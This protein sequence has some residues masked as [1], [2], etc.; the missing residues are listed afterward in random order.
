[1][2]ILVAESSF[3]GSI[4]DTNFWNQL[5]S[6]E[7]AGLEGIYVKYLPELF[8]Y[9]MGINS[10]RS[11]IKD[12]IQELFIDL[13]KYRDS[14]KHTDNVKLYLYKSLSNKICKEIGRDKKRCIQNKISS[15]EYIFHEESVEDKFISVQVNEEIKLKLREA[16]EGLSIRR[17]QVI[18]HLFFESHSYEETSRIMGINVES[19]YT[20]AWKAISSLKKSILIFTIFW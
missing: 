17:R 19:I 8:R 1:M 12:C 6:G 9:G 18:Q 11:F 4:D 13:W 5:K 3:N 7:K 2:Q 20:L 10:D 16:L 15:Y 14:I